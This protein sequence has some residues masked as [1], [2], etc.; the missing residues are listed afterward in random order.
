[1]EE[2]W[3]ILLYRTSQGDSPVEEFIRSLELKGQ[4]KVRDVINLLRI[5]G[6][7]LGLPHIKKLTGTAFWEIRILG[8]DSIRIL[9]I[10]TTG[11][12]FL[13]LH[14][15]KKKKNKTPNKEI[16]IAEERLADHK[17]RI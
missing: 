7:K 4:S 8:S 10:A 14:G 13:L 12:T 9:Y 15:F 6:T 1:M 17:S 5:Y 11:K 3:N 2:K 16:R